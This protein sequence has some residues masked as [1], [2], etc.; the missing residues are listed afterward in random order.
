M[1]P[2]LPL[3]RRRER[4]RRD[5]VG[6]LCRKAVWGLTVALT[7][8]LPAPAAAERGP[9]A[10]KTDKFLSRLSSSSEPQRVIIR[11]KPGAQ[12]LVGRKVERSG[13]RVDKVHKLIPAVSARVSPRALAELAADPDVD[14]VSVDAVVSAFGK[15]SSSTTNVAALRQ[16]LGIASWFQGWNITVAIL[17]SG[18]AASGD[19]DWRI[20]GFYDFTGGRGGVP[21]IPYD[22][23]GH[24]THVAGLIG[25]NGWS[26]RGGAV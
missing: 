18:L 26:S 22:D 10:A 2:L 3:E 23:Y 7:L 5:G 20:R 16:S 9:G 15:T 6:Y 24:G 19:F 12:A 4:L 25:S 13:D 17:D 14:A 1:A 11:T 21:A 8:V